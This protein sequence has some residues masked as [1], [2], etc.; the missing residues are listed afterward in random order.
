M[1]D[2]AVTDVAGSLKSLLDEF[3]QELSLIE[4]E[5]EI[6]MAVKDDVGLQQIRDR[7][8][9]MWK[10]C[11]AAITE[12]RLIMDQRISVAEAGGVT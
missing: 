7:L 12:A 5:M 9:V 8:D 10:Q 6:A 4:R 3:A 2:E 1:S 11:E